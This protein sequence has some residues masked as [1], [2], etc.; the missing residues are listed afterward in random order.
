MNTEALK[1][2]ISLPAIDWF[3]YFLVLSSQSNGQEKRSSISS[4]S[5]GVM[6]N[7]LC[8]MY[9]RHPQPLAD[10]EW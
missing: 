9:N 1:P 10:S 4:L 3:S 8:Y 6:T 2:N 7:P 5:T